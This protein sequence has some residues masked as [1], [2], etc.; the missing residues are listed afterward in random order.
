[1]QNSGQTQS[2]TSSPIT[3]PIAN[4]PSNTPHSQP[5]NSNTEPGIAGK[6]EFPEPHTLDE[7]SV[8]FDKPYTLEHFGFSEDL[9]NIDTY[10][11]RAEFI[12][13]FVK[14]EIEG[15][16]M[17]DNLDSYKSIISEMMSTLDVHPQTS[18]VV[19]LEK[20]YNWVKNYLKPSRETARKRNQYA[21]RF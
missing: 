11:E 17:E 1:M 19:K 3:T 8:A 9:Q 10:R 12:D 5:S 6:R 16:N 13:N 18:G 2:V 21:T 14:E 15:W 7:Y 4:L 20:L